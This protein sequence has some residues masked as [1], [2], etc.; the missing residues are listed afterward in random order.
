MVEIIVLWGRGAQDSNGV[1]SVGPEV[2]ICIS[3]T[4]TVVL[5]FKATDLVC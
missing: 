1:Q 4:V 5:N 2:V 3:D